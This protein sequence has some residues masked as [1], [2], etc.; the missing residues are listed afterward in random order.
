MLRKHVT[1]QMDPTWRK[2][3]VIVENLPVENSSLITPNLETN[4]DEQPLDK[5]KVTVETDNEM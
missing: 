2:H 3:E 4:E 1:P 5:R